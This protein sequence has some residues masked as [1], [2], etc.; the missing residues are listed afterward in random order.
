[1]KR[2]IDTLLRRCHSCGVTNTSPLY[3]MI[4]RRLVG[5]TLAEFVASRRATSSW[6]AMA[7][8]ITETT[9]VE[10]SDETLRRWF[11][12]RLQVEVRVHP[13][14]NGTPP[15]TP[16]PSRPPVQP[17]PAPPPRPPQPARADSDGDGSGERA[18]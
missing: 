11:V 8:E 1:M 18:A 15:G 2:G 4:E 3:R 12:D 9:D 16:A 7:A 10:V 17:K 5:Q 14:S 6:T 13:D